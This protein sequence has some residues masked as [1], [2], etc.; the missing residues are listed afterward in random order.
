MILS[1]ADLWVARDLRA[2]KR[3]ERVKL[4]C[5]PPLSTFM[6]GTVETRT[7][8]RIVIVQ[9]ICFRPQSIRDSKQTHFQD[10]VLSKK[11]CG[12]NSDRS[13]VNFPI[14]NHPRRLCFSSK[15]LPSLP[16]PNLR[17][18]AKA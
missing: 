14:R 12:E 4:T 5:I 3:R 18:L 8:L 16:T 2:T 6:I 9:I 11:Q 15:S 10:F 13:S 1:F 7:P 17:G